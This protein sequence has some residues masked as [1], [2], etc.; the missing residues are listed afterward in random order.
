MIGQLQRLGF[1]FDWERTFMSSDAVMYRWS[2]WLFLTLLEAGLVY[3]G[4]GTVD[5]CDTCQ[6][7]LAT[8]QVENGACWRCHNP[9]RLIE[10]PS[11]TCGSAPTCR[12]TTAA[13]EERAD[14]GKWDEMALASQRFVLGRVDGVELELS[15]AGRHDA[16]RVHAARRGARAGALR[17]DLPQA[18]RDRARGQRSAGVRRALGGA[19]LG[20]PSS[21]ARATREHDAARGHRAHAARPRR[22]R[23]RCRS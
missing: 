3:R 6:T 4:T 23:R 1:S 7:T 11:G 14:S 10:R 21:A 16:D 9:V 13:C 15:D 20:R 8:I 5:W 2:Q 18:P 17:A 19:A 12:R 22:R